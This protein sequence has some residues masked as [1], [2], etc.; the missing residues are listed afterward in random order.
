LGIQGENLTQGDVVGH[1][2]GVDL[3]LPDPAGDDLGVL[4][5]EIEN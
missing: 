2:L 1:D 3:G 5:A 4:G